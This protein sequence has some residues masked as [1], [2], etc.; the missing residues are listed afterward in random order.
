M[1]IMSQNPKSM[2]QNHFNTSHPGLRRLT[3]R[4]ILP[5]LT[6]GPAHLSPDGTPAGILP[7]KMVKNRDLT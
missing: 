2:D 7:A 4:E 6:E 3:L 5:V 1:T